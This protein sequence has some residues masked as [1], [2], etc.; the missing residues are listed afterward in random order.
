MSESPQPAPAR[1]LIVDDEQ[2]QRRALASLTSSWGFSV[3]T[4][5]DGHDALEK[6]A[7]FRAHVLVTDLNMPRM[8]GFELLRQLSVQGHSPVS[9]VLTAFGSM[10][11]A[12]KTVH[13]LGAFWFL[14]KPIQPTALKVLLERAASQGKPQRG[15]RP[16]APP[17]EL[18]RVARRLGRH[19]GSDA[20]S[21]LD[22]APSRSVE[23][24]RVGHR[25]ERHREGVSRPSRS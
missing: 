5:C 12:I 8:D 6:L 3:E 20:G 10:E 13:D 21:L 14:E 4:A 16:A 11:N 25:R 2:D 17:I 22:D 23:R 15:N 18:P 7:G 24:R 19:V 1:V 9:I